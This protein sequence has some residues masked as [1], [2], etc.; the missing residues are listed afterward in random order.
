MDVTNV[1][2]AA[3]TYTVTLT[4][5]SIPLET[6]DVIILSGT[7]EKVTFSVAKEVIGDYTAGVSGLTRAIHVVK[8]AEFVVPNLQVVL[9]PESREGYYRIT[10]DI[11]NIG[12]LPGVYQLGCK[13][14]D[15]K[16]QPLKVEL[17]ADEKETVTLTGAES[18][19][20]ELAA[21]YKNEE[22]DLRAHVVSIEGLSETVTFAARPPPKPVVN[23]Q[24]LSLYSYYGGRGAT[25]SNFEGE[26]KNISDESL[27]DVEIMKT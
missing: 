2:K 21:N 27:T 3:G 7:S 11:E 12:A 5:D 10:M 24:V 19:I 13:V 17:N 14:N 26:I 4:I 18:T 23:L 20:H 25:W 8:P 22:I 16:I 9:A 15:E 6:K 1:G